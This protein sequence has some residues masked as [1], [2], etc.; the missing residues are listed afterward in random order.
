MAAFQSSDDDF[1]LLR[2]F[3]REHARLL[4]VLEVEISEIAK[5]LDQLDK[6]DDADPKMWHR[7]TNT[8]RGHEGDSRS[9]ELLDQLEE[10]ILRYGECFFRR[11]I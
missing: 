10:K 8:M 2:G 5:A 6:E 9:T 11:E 1:F 3:K 7:L 4:Q